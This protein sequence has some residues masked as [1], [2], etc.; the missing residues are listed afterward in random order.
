MLIS[1]T[2][3]ND[4]WPEKAH[5]QKSQLGNMG[6]T[7]FPTW[8]IAVIRPTFH[9]CELNQRQFFFS[10]GFVPHSSHIQRSS[11]KSLCYSYTLFQLPRGRCSEVNDEIEITARLSDLLCCFP[12]LPQEGRE[13]SRKSPQAIEQHTQ[14]WII[15]KR[16]CVCL[17]TQRNV[18]MFKPSK[19]KEETPQAVS[20]ALSYV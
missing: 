6:G 20:C 3:W 8:N 10:R 7:T 9:V 1:R 17:H 19:G 16:A 11:F 13:S 4:S 15:L 18:Y 2:L 5:R 12:P 14:P